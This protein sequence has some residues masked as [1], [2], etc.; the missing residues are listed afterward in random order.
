MIL[1]Q[2]K[3]TE[4]KGLKDKTLNLSDKVTEI[5]GDNGTGKS[6]IKNAYNWVLTGFCEGKKDYKIFNEK[7]GNNVD[8]T[9][10]FDEFILQ[11]KATKKTGKTLYTYHTGADVDLM[12][13]VSKTDYTDFVR[14]KI[15]KLYN[16]LVDIEQLTGLTN[17]ERKTLF[18]P[19]LSS[20]V[21]RPS[22][23]IGSDKSDREYLLG[24]KAYSTD[25][26]KT[27]ADDIRTT[28]KAVKDKGFE[29]EALQTNKMTLLKQKEELGDVEKK[30]ES[31]KILKEKEE[32]ATKEIE[33][34][35]QLR[36]DYKSRGAEAIEKQTKSLKDISLVKEKSYL[37]STYSI[38]PFENDLFE[39]KM[40]L[41]KFQTL[42]EGMRCDKC[43]SVIGKEHRE[44][45]IEKL[46]KEIKKQENVVAG[47]S[48]DIK[49]KDAEWKKAKKSLDQ[50]VNKMQK[51]IEIGY[52]KY[53]AG[54]RSKEDVRNTF[55]EELEKLKEVSEKIIL[56][57]NVLKSLGE[58]GSNLE[59]AR[60]KLQ[61]LQ[62]TLNV[63]KQI[64]R[65]ALEKVQ[66][67][68]K[69]ITPEG[70]TIDLFKENLDGSIADTFD[71]K[72][73]GVNL[74]TLN[75]AKRT[76]TLL[77]LNKKL[78]GHYLNVEIPIFVDSIEKT[79]NLDVKS[80]GRQIILLRVPEKKTTYN[81]ITI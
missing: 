60:V 56:K 28:N 78:S 62:Y 30:E 25:D 37:E 66:S 41:K 22:D 4:F 8:V 35:H 71:I 5:V 48:Q 76:E 16:V 80:D 38:K 31:I 20:E 29:I 7:G 9:L 49:T 63:L 67:S 75:D 13:K 58:M 55:R 54:I 10:I 81:K 79:Q 69:E 73:G 70:V 40:K 64:Q 68:I 65:V 59:V 24:S 50:K 74:A 36:G 3:I 45:Y 39:K 52:Q 12:S 26:L 27:L 19:L 53:D 46:E 21:V 51:E 33:T 57:K 32:Q 14:E 11:K 17:E 23:I 6:T 18:F 43:Q 1:K 47:R 2:I 34:L 72:C 42:E 44:A 77:F 61:N 15:G